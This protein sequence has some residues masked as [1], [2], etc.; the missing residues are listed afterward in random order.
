M[1][2]QIE[3]GKE[4]DRGADSE[5]QAVTA[6]EVVKSIEKGFRESVKPTWIEWQK[7]V[8]MPVHRVAYP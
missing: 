4:I 8:R 6:N 1:K 7:D 3:N 5:N 2:K